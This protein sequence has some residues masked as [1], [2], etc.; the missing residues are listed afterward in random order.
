MYTQR[1][2]EREG[3]KE[4]EREREGRERLKA[5]GYFLTEKGDC[6]KKKEK[7]KQGNGEKCEQSIMNIF[8]KRIIQ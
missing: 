2:G 5:E 8:I 6:G 1:E 4:R 3:G 7:T